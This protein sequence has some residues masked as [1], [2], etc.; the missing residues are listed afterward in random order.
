MSVPTTTSNEPT[1]A[2]PPRFC[3]LKRVSSLVLIAML[4]LGGLRWWWGR[5]AEAR[6][7]E[8]VAAARARR[9]PILPEDFPTPNV[10]EARNAAITLQR[11]SGALVQDTN[12][13]SVESQW[14]SGPP[15]PQEMLWVEVVAEYNRLPLQLVRLARSQPQADWGIRVPSSPRLMHFPRLSGQSS[16][17]LLEQWVALVDHSRGNDAEALEH[18]LD[19]LGQADA[20]GQASSFYLFHLFSLTSQARAIYV[21]NLITPDLRIT[22]D[23]ETPSPHD[24]A[25]S[26]SQVRQ[27]IARLLDERE[28]R[29]GAIGMF[30]GIR[31]VA[32]DLAEA[33]A[34]GEDSSSPARTAPAAGAW[35]VRP[36]FELDASRLTTKFSL[37]RSAAGQAN[38]PAAAA[39]YPQ[40]PFSRSKLDNYVHGVSSDFGYQR[41]REMMMHFPVM[42]DRRAAA[43]ALAVRLYRVDH[44]GQLPAHLTD[45]V[46]DYLP[47]VPIDPMAADGRPF[48]YH[49][50][51]HPPV[52]YSV[53]R[54]GIDDGGTS[55]P[56][57]ITVRYRFDFPDAV[58][59]LDPLPPR[60]RR[61]SGNSGRPTTGKAP[62]PG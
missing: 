26:R 54:D 44:D 56:Y 36:M 21:L 58:Y 62:S 12:W 2:Y 28:L 3:W 22:A 4:A 51:A 17:L 40:V 18:V 61:A 29:Q 50:A 48:G 53:G 9:E 16:L 24:G 6:L 14:R 43:I 57:D 31:L 20:M 42:T 59:P 39:I 37:M 27:V 55:L 49:P 33:L 52:I 10:P 60:K 38:W 19:L 45:L 32:L 5:V 23:G 7:R 13:N 35:L 34:R 46:P 15:T 8:A 1:T 25:A 30:D 11:A 41:L 47:A